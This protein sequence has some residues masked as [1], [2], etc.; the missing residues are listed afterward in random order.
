MLTY[1]LKC[2]KVFKNKNG[3]PMLSS[4]CAVCSNKKWRFMQKQEVKGLWSSLGSAIEQNPIISWHSVLIQL[5]IKWV[6]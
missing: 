5:C 1:L 4:R 2:K 6:K 3:R